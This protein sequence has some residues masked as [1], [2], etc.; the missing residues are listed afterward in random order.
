MYGLAFQPAAESSAPSIVKQFKVKS[1]AL[2]CMRR[3]AT[4]GTGPL[5]VVRRARATAFALCATA[6]GSTSLHSRQLLHAGRFR[7]LTCRLDL[8]ALSER[9]LTK[10]VPA[11]DG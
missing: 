2:S 1:D 3:G 10:L 7:H 11:S 6:V 5:F 8:H 4:D 9:Y